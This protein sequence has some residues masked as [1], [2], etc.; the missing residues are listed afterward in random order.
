MT[1]ARAKPNPELGRVHVRW[2]QSGA[3]RYD[4]CYGTIEE[5]PE[6][7][8]ISYHKTDGIHITI[9]V[10]SL[11]FYEFAPMVQNQEPP[12]GIVRQPTMK[13]VSGRPDELD[14]PVNVR[15]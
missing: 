1:L 12:Q 2:H 10:E 14:W 9:P 13:I 5:D 8:T 15:Y 3:D 7:R 11:L 6:M 4:E